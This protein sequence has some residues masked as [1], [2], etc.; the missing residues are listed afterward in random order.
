MRA[1]LA[2]IGIAAIAVVV[3]MSL[4]MLSIEQEEGATMPSVSFNV[5]GGK[6]PSFKAKTGTIDIKSTE[7]TIELPTV[8]MR[9]TTISL[10]SV[11]VKQ[12]SDEG[13]A[14]AEE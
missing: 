11:E 7:K 2:L 13:E 1:I 14:A 10:P 12:A 6:M 3:L 9:N 5:E 8:E 4:G